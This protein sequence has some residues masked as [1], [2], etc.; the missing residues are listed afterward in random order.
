MMNIIE[1]KLPKKLFLCLNLER[2]GFN[3]YFQVC[4]FVEKCTKKTIPKSI[5]QKRENLNK[6]YASWYILINS[7]FICSFILLFLHS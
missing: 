3:V 2:E 5:Q 1:H 7:Y 6:H 4:S